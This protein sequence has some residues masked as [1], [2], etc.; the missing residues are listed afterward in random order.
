MKSD[1][2]FC[3]LSDE[4]VVELA[5]M[6]DD[7]AFAHIVTRY[8][9]FVY[10][11]V[12][13]YYI[14]GADNDDLIQEGMIGLFKAVRGFKSEMGSFSNF[15][16]LCVNRQILTAVKNSTRNKHMPLNTYI[17]L[18]GHST[19]ESE[20]EYIPEIAGEDHS[21][22]PENI[23]ISRENVSGITYRIN[24]NLSKLE[25]KVLALYLDGHP[26]QDIA[27]KIGKDVKSVDNAIQRIR[28]KIEKI[29]EG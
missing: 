26:Y 10:S 14:K 5:K 15:A 28:K 29:L 2:P 21:Q 18:N 11:K 7:R 12:K 9:N 13:V 23:F 19:E 25:L 20:D 4:Q 17:S 8:K 22:N 1:L 16:S 3:E 27:E 6:G 24:Q